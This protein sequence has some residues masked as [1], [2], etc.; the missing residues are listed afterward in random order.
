MGVG[1]GGVVATGGGGVAGVV[2]VTGGGVGVTGAMVVTGGATGGG[3]WEVLGAG[4]WARVV[5]LRVVVEVEVEEVDFVEAAEEVELASAAARVKSLENGDH[6]T[7]SLGSGNDPEPP[8]RSTTTLMKS[9]QIWAGKV[10]PATVMPWTLY[11]DW[12]TPFAFG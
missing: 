12:R 3:C 11:I 8:S 6:V 4:G 7:G 9:C 2:G 1:A 10:P 5:V